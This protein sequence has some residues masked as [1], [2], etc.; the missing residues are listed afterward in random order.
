MSLGMKNQGNADQNH[1]AQGV[2]RVTRAVFHKDYNAQTNVSILGYCE[3][4]LYYTQT[5]YI[6][7][8]IIDSKSYFHAVFILISLTIEFET[9]LIRTHWY[10]AS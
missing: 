7:K 4:I 10:C 2:R 8:I 3:A 9:S 5:L 6:C 1:D